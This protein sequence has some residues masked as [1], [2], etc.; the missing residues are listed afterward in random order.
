MEKLIKDDF[1]IK[2]LN[3]DKFS[4]DRISNRELSHSNTKLSITLL[5]QSMLSISFLW[6]SWVIDKVPTVT[7]SYCLLYYSKVN[8]R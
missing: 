4:I 8:Y 5:K 1:L 6:K 2:S 7:L 3:I